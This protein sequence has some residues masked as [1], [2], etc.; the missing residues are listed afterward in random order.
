[1]SCFTRFNN[2]EWS[3][4][5]SGTQ[6]IV[7]PQPITKSDKLQF[8]E[9]KK[10]DGIKTSISRK[11]ESISENDKS[12]WEKH[13]VDWFSK[14][15]LPTQPF[16]LFMNKVSPNLSSANLA[17]LPFDFLHHFESGD[18]YAL[19]CLPTNHIEAQTLYSFVNQYRRLK[20]EGAGDKSFRRVEEKKLQIVQDETIY[21]MPSK[22]PDVSI[23][24]LISETNPSK[25]KNL[26]QL[27]IQPIKSISNTSHKI[28]ADHIVITCSNTT[29]GSLTSD[30]RKI[31]NQIPAATMSSSR[32][33]QLP[34][35]A[36]KIA[37]YIALDEGNVTNLSTVSERVNPRWNA[38]VQQFI[39]R[40]KSANSRPIYLEYLE[41]TGAVPASNEAHKK[42]SLLFAFA[43]SVFI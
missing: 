13:F 17:A 18:R 35:S 31:V 40:T 6:R 19:N 1:M 10:D 5:V 32:S 42:V 37:P 29:Q 33:Q 26:K 2:K 30:S 11:P 7:V 34:L 14:Q 24:V 27:E 25:I 12:V 39:G 21:S 28:P 23:P 36:D 22:I 8:R 15:I 4:D 3:K 20:L 38:E 16:K 41:K 9:G 43:C